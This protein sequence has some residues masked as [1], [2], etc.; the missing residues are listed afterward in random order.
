M[1]KTIKKCPNPLGEHGVC[2]A[3]DRYGDRNGCAAIKCELLTDE[4]Y[5]SN[6]D[7]LPGLTSK[8]NEDLAKKIEK[9]K[10]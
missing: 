10:R 2:Y 3:F 4:T 7:P 6:G 1:D 5:S 8:I 9:E